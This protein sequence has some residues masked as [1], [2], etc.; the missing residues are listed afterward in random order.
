MYIAQGVSPERGG[1]IR[2]T[3]ARCLPRTPQFVG[4]T[5]LSHRNSFAYFVNCT[6]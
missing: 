2:L 3:N 6:S 4:E 5:I 1:L